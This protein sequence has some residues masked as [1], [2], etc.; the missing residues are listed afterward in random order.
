M[1]R[2][3][4]E[5]AMIRTALRQEVVTVRILYKN[6]FSRERITRGEAGSQ[7]GTILRFRGG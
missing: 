5:R 2:I 7:K 3:R 4:A 6:N 1:G